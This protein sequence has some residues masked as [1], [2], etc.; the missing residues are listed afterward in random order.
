MVARERPT[1]L[2]V[3][4]K[5]LPP[6]D[7][8]IGVAKVCPELKIIYGLPGR[9]NGLRDDQFVQLP[10]E[11]GVSISDVVN[12]L[13]LGRYLW[14]TRRRL[15]ACHFFSTKLILFGP[16]VSA[17]VGVPSIVTVTGL[18]RSFV[19]KGLM[20]RI[21]R[22]L[23][24]LLLRISA[25]LSQRVLFQNRGDMARLCSE[26]PE[27][28]RKS[29]Y[30]GSAVDLHETNS[31][32]FDGSSL[33]I[34]LVSRL[35]PS[36]G[37]ADFLCVA[38]TLKSSGYEFVLVGPTSPGYDLLT[39]R[40]REYDRSGLIRYLGE[41]DSARVASEMEKAHIFLFPSYGEGLPRVLLECGYA[42]ICP[43]AYEIAATLDLLADGR[44]FLVPLHD[45]AAL[46]SA[47]RRLKDN[48]DL[49]RA[50]A[51]QYQAYILEHYSMQAYANRLKAVLRALGVTST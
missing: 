45:V 35:L 43:V 31:R 36:K 44:G 50:N 7:Y 23:Y 39:E 8:R 3:A 10:F 25:S 11:E 12:F 38:E 42:G 48:R 33:R 41:L 6:N 24:L 26:L 30:I 28:A 21:L 37:I 2:F 34:L 9:T 14:S 20:A 32:T 5:K 13:Q 40:V 4:N 1:I 27:V 46:V 16:I 17:V 15:S 47:L 18:G 22:V 51:V 29:E 19:D 49:L